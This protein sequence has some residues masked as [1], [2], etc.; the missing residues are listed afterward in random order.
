MGSL[1]VAGM[2][3]GGKA[4]EREDTLVQSCLSSEQ[5]RRCV[6]NSSGILSAGILLRQQLRVSRICRGSIGELERVVFKLREMIL[7]IRFERSLTSDCCQESQICPAA[8]I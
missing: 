6:L 3:K 5:S 4:D 1:H 8:E 7:L 2:S